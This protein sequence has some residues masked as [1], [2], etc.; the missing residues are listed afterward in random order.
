MNNTFCGLFHN[1]PECLEAQ[2]AWT[3]QQCVQ[4]ARGPM[5]N[6]ELS[7]RRNRRFHAYR[8][9]TDT[10]MNVANNAANV[11]NDVANAANAANNAVIHTRLLKPAETR[12]AVP[13]TCSDNEGFYT[14][15][16]PHMNCR[17]HE[18]GYCCQYE[19]CPICHEDIFET[20]RKC[21]NCNVVFHSS[22]IEQWIK[23]RGEFCRDCRT[24][25]K[26]CP[27]C[28]SHFQFV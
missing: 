8:R 20:G 22:C 10:T 12:L 17:N 9:P 23:T 15:Q 27:S 11:A 13:G 21:G 25:R 4:E 1:Q 7:Q 28:R 3:G 5:R 18:H 2:C 19:P 26:T 14:T 16:P 24:N 6:L